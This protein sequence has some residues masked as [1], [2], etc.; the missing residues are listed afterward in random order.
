MLLG[1][2]LAN[3]VTTYFVMHY[4][5][6][7]LQRVTERMDEQDRKLAAC[8]QELHSLRRELCRLEQLSSDIVHAHYHMV[9]PETNTP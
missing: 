1:V 5:I 6:G 3:G 2:V 4:F 7:Y 9:E 8:Q